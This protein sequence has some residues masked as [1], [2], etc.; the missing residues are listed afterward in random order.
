MFA[1]VILFA[2]GFAARY[3][4]NLDCPRHGLVAAHNPASNS[5][6][7]QPAPTYVGPEVCG[8]CHATIA[9]TY[10]KTGMGR[11][12]YLPT[13]SNEIERYSTEGNTFVHYGIGDALH[14]QRP[15]T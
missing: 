15:F 2:M 4:D 1:G 6:K 12:F 11:S 14:A 10:E 3:V 9:A 8:T 7:N 13:K 5:G